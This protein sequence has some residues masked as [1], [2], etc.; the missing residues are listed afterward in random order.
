MG[1]TI[2]KNIKFEENPE[3]LTLLGARF[4]I[5]IDTTID[6]NIQLPID[7]MRNEIRQQLGR[8]FSPFG[9]NY[10]PEISR[11]VKDCT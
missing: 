9:K 10:S 3:Y 8:D 2:L 4:S 11:T 7:P 6:D 1:E 5:H